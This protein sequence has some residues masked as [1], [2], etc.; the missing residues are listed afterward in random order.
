MK[1]KI[2]LNDGLGSIMDHLDNYQKT[3]DEKC[4]LFVR[5]LA[6]LGVNVAMT[7]L[8]FEGVGDSPRGADFGVRV[9][10]NGNITHCIIS[11]TSKP[12]IDDDGRVFYP[13]LAW[14]FGAGNYYNGMTSP[15]PKAREFGM[16]IGTYPEQKHV[17]NPGFWYYYD[18]NHDAIRSYGTQATMPMYKASVEI[19]ENIH[20]V[21]KEVFA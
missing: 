14:E 20:K 16:G 17:P 5:Q 2:S 1:L 4:E 21:A 18:S 11:V 8:A 3:L 19:I 13:H 10:K 15:N 12:Q 6:D 7:T 9:D